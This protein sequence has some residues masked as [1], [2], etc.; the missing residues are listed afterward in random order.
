MTD[1]EA[2]VRAGGAQSARRPGG[3]AGGAFVQQRKDGDRMSMDKSPTPENT[4]L[5]ASRIDSA[6]SPC[7]KGDTNKIHQAHTV[8]VQY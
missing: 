2:T 6:L 8:V 5:S 1:N 7:L 4:G 3:G